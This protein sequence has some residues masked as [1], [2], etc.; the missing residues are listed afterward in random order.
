MAR[1]S[2]CSSSSW[3]RRTAPTSWTSG[4][5][6]RVSKC[7]ATTPEIRRSLCESFTANISKEIYCLALPQRWSARFTNAFVLL[8]AAV[9][10]LASLTMRRQRW[11]GVCAMI[12]TRS[13]SSLTSMCS[14]YRQA[15]TAP[16]PA[17]IP[18]GRAVLG[19]FLARC[20]RWTRVRSYDLRM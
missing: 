6:A 19:H 1:V 5:P 7:L 16:K 3:T 20:P 8:T 11:S 18:A 13:S 12:A 10:W 17:T 14:T 2:S 9:T 4:L 15:G